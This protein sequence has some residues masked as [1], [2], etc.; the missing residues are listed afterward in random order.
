[1]LELVGGALLFLFFE[2]VYRHTRWLKNSTARIQKLPRKG[3]DRAAFVL[4][5]KRA[6]PWSAR[7]TGE[8][9]SRVVEW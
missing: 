2:L 7:S 4:F 9:R 5:D 8:P 6:K 3:R 1:M